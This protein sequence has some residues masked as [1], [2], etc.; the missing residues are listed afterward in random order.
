M[1]PHFLP[2][3][4][5][6]GLYLFPMDPF[7]PIHS[8]A[9][10]KQKYLVLGSPSGNTRLRWRWASLSF[11]NSI[12]VSLDFF[13]VLLRLAFR[14]SS[15]NSSSIPWGRHILVWTQGPSSSFLLPLWS[16]IPW[17]LPFLCA[18]HQL[19]EK[20]SIRDITSTTLAQ[21][22]EWATVTKEQNTHPT[23]TRS[24]AS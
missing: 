5:F 13:L 11:L 9:T 18:N 22:L 17:P 4:H 24:E 2:H 23:K 20:L 8:F 21:D 6:L 12:R 16:F 14:S 3:L 1:G 7:S 19:T 15:S 10:N